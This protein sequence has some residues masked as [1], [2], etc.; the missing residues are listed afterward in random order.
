MG[1]LAT[2]PAPVGSLVKS[3]PGTS[4]V[5][6]NPDWLREWF[7]DLVEAYE[8][9]CGPA[10]V[11]LVGAPADDATPRL[12]VLANPPVKK[13]VRLISIEPRYFRGYRRID[14]AVALHEML[15]VIEGRNSSGKTSLAE[16]IEWVLT[17]VL[18]RRAS[19]QYGH[20]RELANCI[21]NEFT[22]EGEQT[23]VEI[24]LLIDGV[25]T[26][27]RRTLTVDYMTQQ[28][29]E[30]ESV[31]TVDGVKLGNS[32][33]SR[34]LADLFAGLH[35]I[36]MQHTLRQ[37]V[38]DQPSERRRYFERL[39][40]I[41]EL[42]ELISRAVVGDATLDS[43][44]LATG[45]P[46]LEAIETLLMS[47]DDPQ[48]RESLEKLHSAEPE[49]V[50]EQFREALIFAACRIFADLAQPDCTLNQCQDIVE[51]AQARAREVE[52]PILGPLRKPLDQPIP[53]TS[54]LDRLQKEASIASAALKQA[55][56]A[57]ASLDEARQAIAKALDVLV[58]AGLI[59]ISGA[60]AQECPVCVAPDGTLGADRIAEVRSWSPLA[61]ALEN[62][63]KAS[64]ASC[65]SLQ[66]EVQ[67]LQE[68]F[69]RFVVEL[70]TESE[71]KSMLDGL[72]PT[73][74]SAI[75]TS[76]TDAATLADAAKNLDHSLEQVDETRPLVPG[77][78][79]ELA[80][81]LEA[82]RDQMS[83][84][85]DLVGASAREE[86][87]YLARE[88]WLSAAH[89]V[90]SVSREV[91]WRAARRKA[92]AR[93]KSIREALIALREEIIEDARETFSS[94]ITEV[95]NL[96]RRD[97]GARFSQ[98]RIPRA[99]GRGYKLELEVKAAISDADETREVDA[100][101]VFS[102]SQINVIGIAAYVTRSRLLGHR[103]LVFDDPVQSMDEEHFRSF[104]DTLL[105]QLL[106]EGFQV[107]VLTHS[108]QFA[109]GISQYHYHRADYMTLRARF[110]KRTGC[111]V[112]EGSRR[113]SE[114][115]KMAERL[116]EEGKLEE[117][118]LRVRLGI[119]RL[120]L[121]VKKRAEP[122]FDPD[123]W[124]DATAEHMWDNGGVGTAIEREVPN[125]GTHLKAIL[126]QS[127]VGAHDKKA[128]SQTDLNDAIAYLRSLLAPL[129]IGN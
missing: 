71:L 117:A 101:R 123:S 11:R 116:G 110:S 14:N 47:V 129:R 8:R 79:K 97:T 42:T 75:R 108:D 55:E 34:L 95:W 48:A 67:T 38:H 91:A 86:T 4:A 1:A 45:S 23:W 66:A 72:P 69:G 60:E 82:F 2:L 59:E 88:R 98:L 70:P 43:Y 119:E 54:R 39:L 10:E 9:G 104:A 78:G 94:Q 100:L 87:T 102:E 80:V 84:L 16:A 85:E 36:L 109:R 127:V 115:L 26:R 76:C 112:D 49:S 103:V 92:Q 25:E 44:R 56:T 89:S 120:Y 31:L 122:T 5:A 77:P 51:E 41:D 106:D 15:V 3:F 37:F 52:L 27:L 83:R 6:D 65:V 22:P 13:K 12:Q 121:L 105:G 29:S 61:S 53:D 128:T 64:A 19:G 18:S 107:V 74:Q 20:P 90:A 50:Q 93:L 28:G 118:W 68:L 46:A 24:V 62:A 32:E 7:T 124:R 40:Q 113:V 126:D 33:E 114:R 63:R 99:R 57:T 125:A 96:L 73:L 17:G 81:A 21:A 58:A 111:Q 35:P 30:P